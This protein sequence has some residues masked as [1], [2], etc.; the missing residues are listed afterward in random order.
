MDSADGF[1]VTANNV[2]ALS[3]VDDAGAEQNI[4]H[5]DAQKVLVLGPTR[6]PEI[7]MMMYSPLNIDKRHVFEDFDADL[8]TSLPD[9]LSLGL[10]GNGIYIDYL[11]P[12][13]LKLSTPNIAAGDGA[14]VTMNNQALGTL[15]A[16]NVYFCLRMLQTQNVDL[17]FG[18]RSRNN[19]NNQ[20]RFRW[21]CGSSGTSVLACKAQNGSAE[22]NWTTN[23][24]AI[25]E[26]RFFCISFPNAYGQQ[27]GG[28]VTFMAA[29][30]ENILRT[31]ATAQ[32]GDSA[33]PS[34]SDALTPFLQLRTYDAP[35]IVTLEWESVYLITEW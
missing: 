10:I 13:R 22:S 33:I 23:W 26:R 21:A 12:S 34:P 4:A 17:Q 14:V 1:R 8:G 15:A 6:A 7:G 5:L 32:A 24:A 31:V 27:A 25:T 19:I 35:G 29:D 2:G 11:P 9:R 20:L 18:L 30:A 3:Q 16:T 28:P